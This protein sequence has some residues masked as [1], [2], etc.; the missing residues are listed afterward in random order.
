MDNLMLFPMMWTVSV[1]QEAVPD[2]D[3]D[4]DAGGES[5]QTKINNNE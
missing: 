5:W 2:K 1:K 3:T 4:K